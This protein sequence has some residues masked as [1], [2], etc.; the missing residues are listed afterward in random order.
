VYG[1]FFGFEEKDMNFTS[2]VGKQ[3]FTVE[4]KYC[5][6]CGGLWIRRPGQEV[7]YCG[8]CRAQLVSLFENKKHFARA[9]SKS[10]V[11]IECLQGVSEMEV[12]Q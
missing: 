3:D 4:L 2:L 9:G 10:R 1:H 5:E 8:K 12:R 7:A 11:R 6:R